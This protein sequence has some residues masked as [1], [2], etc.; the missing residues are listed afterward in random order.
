MFN[1]K[2]IKEAAAPGSWRRGY[3]YFQKKLVLNAVLVNDTVEASVKGNFQ[4]AYSVKLNFSP[5]KVSA[6]CDCPLSE[7]WCKHA[8]SV[9]LV[10]I[11]KHLFEEY[12]TK[13]TGQEFEFPDENTPEVA[14]PEGGYKFLLNTS[15]SQKFVRVQI[16]DRS[17]NEAVIDIE[18][19]LRAVIA[20]QN[21]PESGFI[22]NDLQKYEFMFLQFLYKNARV[23]K[24]S[25]S[26]N[27]PLNKMEEALN[28]L[29]QV[30]EVLDIETKTRLVFVKDPWQLV[31]SVNVSLVGNVLLSLH[32]KRPDPVDVLPLEEV[33]YFS[34]YAKWGRYKNIIVP[35]DTALSK[36]PNH[37]LRSTFTDI[38]DA[39]GGKFVY[40]ELPKLK[41]LTTVEISEVLEKLTLE[42]RPPISVLTIEPGENNTI[43]ATLEFEYDGTIVPFGK[44]ADKTPY[45]TVKKPEEEIIYWVKRN[46][47][48]EQE[49]YNFLISQKFIPMQTNNLLLESDDAIDFYNFVSGKLNE[50]WKIKENG[51]FTALKAAEDK[52]KIHT[53]IDFDESID[54]FKVKIS[55]AVGETEISLDIVQSYL[56]QGKKYFYLENEGFVEVPLAEILQFTKSLQNYDAQKIDER[57]FT[58]KTFRAGFVAE[59]T[60]Q[61][62]V[63]SMSDKFEKFWNQI[64]TFN[65]LEEI[66]VSKNVKAELRDYQKKGFNWLW[67]LYSYGLN[68]ILADDMGLGKTLQTLT[69]IQKAKDV[70][71]QQ[72][73]LVVC[74]TSVVFNWE[75]EIDKF[76]PGLK[77]LNL[78]GSARKDLF[79]KIEKSDVVITSYALIRRDIAELKKHNF[80]FLILDE[81]QNIKN[82]E[83]L[84]A[85]CSKQLNANHRIALSGTPI[86]NRISELWS[87]FDFLMPGFLYDL[88]EFNYR[89]TV[90]IQERGDRSVESRLKKQVFPFIL[91]RMK[92]DV[93]KDLP[94][95]IE[96]IAYCKM[97][98]EQKDLYLEVLDSTRE[99]VFSQISSQGFEKSRMSIFAALLRLRQICNHPGLYNKD[100]LNGEIESGKFE[101]LKEMLE[102]IISEGHRILLFSQ[103][104]QMLDIVKEWF[105]K[106]G[107]KYEYLTGETKNRQERVERFNSD[108]SIPVF[109]I[110]LKAGGTG[111]NLTGADYVI[112]Y[113]PWWNP[114]VEDQ[115]T[116]RAHRIGQ[117]KKVFVYRMI[118][119]GSIEEKIMKLKER[120]RDLVDSIIS[121][122]RSIGKALTYEDLK[123]ILTPDL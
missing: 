25:K 112:H 84:T 46:L 94:D 70:D 9:G 3:E 17:K 72:T 11:E 20:M 16:I 31:L 111:L 102:E 87:V 57:L 24:Q 12:L 77:C 74:P 101:H 97:T 48:K 78:T 114:A 14:N 26:F 107:I 43:Q 86:E 22:L 103:F 42:Q 65:T 123:D 80:R 39:D 62:V 33:K 61:G 35:L 68:G 19:I 88:D 27:I 73:T 121:V 4:D 104:V 2:Y 83:S 32:W 30:E 71:G 52:L 99:E 115:A 53:Y 29:S 109:L 82:Y 69:L 108:E 28:L 60:E 44:L 98:P 81:S 105:D 8:V 18:N 40:E 10:S 116:D 100:G 110:S 54:S 51:D 79:N 23:E 106:T 56:Q 59:I 15:S 92:R 36:L 1:F 76:V 66:E 89:Y 34:K 13:T 21:A 120:K 118:T 95:K 37:L 55:C 85:Q 5:D 67:F 58:I 96:N 63:L 41:Q 50:Y 91:R 113:D 7:E 75:A 49:A 45:V 90:P 47:K 6:E 119:K 122:D 64:C 93:A 38:R 117:T